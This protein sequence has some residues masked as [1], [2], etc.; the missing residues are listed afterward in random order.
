MGLLRLQS[1][2]VFTKENGD[3]YTLNDYL[4]GIEHTTSVEDLTDTAKIIFPYSGKFKGRNLFA[5]P[6]PIFEVG[7]KVEIYSGYFPDMVL[8]FTGWISAISAK[9]PVEISVQD[10]MWQLKNTTI[11]YPQKRITYYYGK[12]SKGKASKKP[13]KKPKVIGDAITLHGLLEYMLGESGVG[14]WDWDAPEV[15]L[16]RL[17]FTNVSITKVFETLKD[18]FGLFARFR[19]GKLIVGFQHDARHSETYKYVFNEVV[20]W[21][22]IDDSDLEYQNAKDVQLKIV[23]KLMGLTNTFE[24]ITVGEVDG[25]QRTLFFYWDG[26]TLPKPD[27]KKLAEENLTNSR[28]DGY[29]GSFDTFGYYPII[30][31]DIATLESKKFPERDGDYLVI[32]VKESFGMGGIRQTIHIGNKI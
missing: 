2:V 12:T 22:V 19:N 3:Q 16:G 31:G 20:P 29:R 28:F 5:T 8:R 21:A 9:I 18:K 17:L 10:D 14:D 1:K 4:N 23:A 27:L 6:D 13:L 24:E 30:A 26:V 25:A 32:D 11:T 15:N 7:D